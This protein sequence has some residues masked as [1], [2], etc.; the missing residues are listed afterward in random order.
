M[1]KYHDGYLD[2]NIKVVPFGGKR[3]SKQVLQDRQIQN[4]LLNQPNIK[5]NPIKHRHPGNYHAM[6]HISS[7][8]KFKEPVPL[9]LLTGKIVKEFIDINRF[10]SERGRNPWGSVDTY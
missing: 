8:C 6:G 7:L 9:R 10:F 5:I 1:E 4:I 3:Y 2:G